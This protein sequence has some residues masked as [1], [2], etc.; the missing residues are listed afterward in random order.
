MTSNVYCEG[1]HLI[2]QPIVQM[3]VHSRLLAGTVS[4]WR[5]YKRGV[6]QL[7]PFGSRTVLRLLYLFSSFLHPD[8]GRVED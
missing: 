3:T 6:S 4:E 1:A 8:V 5:L 2:A 7:E